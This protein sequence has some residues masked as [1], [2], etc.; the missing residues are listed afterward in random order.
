MAYK[1]KS[2]LWLESDEEMLLG[3]GRLRLL[4]ALQVCGSISGAAK[5]LGMSYR[6]AWHLIDSSNSHSKQPL[7]EKS[8]GGKNGGGAKLTPYGEKLLSNFEHLAAKCETFLEEEM[9]K[10]DWS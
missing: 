6:K 1:V 10:M 3:M 4:K 2:R 5:E 8:T 7:V 9:D